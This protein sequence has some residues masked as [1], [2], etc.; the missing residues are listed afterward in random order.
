MQSNVAQLPLTDRIWA[1][2]ETNKKPV[3]AGIALLLAAGLIIWFV[4]WEQDQKELAASRALSDVA[5]AHMGGSAP[6]KDS[7]AAYLKVAASYP[8]SSAAARALLLAAGSL[9]TE[10]KYAEAQAQFEKFL[11][12]QQGSPFTAEA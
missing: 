8:K 2:F 3:I 1:W 12:S 7:S 11:R 4:L 6:G 10:G 5:T 9:F